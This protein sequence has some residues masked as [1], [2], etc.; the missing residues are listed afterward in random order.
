MMFSENV[1][2]D[3]APGSILALQFTQCSL[4][5]LARLH[6]ADINKGKK[7]GISNLQTTLQTVSEFSYDEFR[8]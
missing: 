2:G 1:I 4:C 7:K 3:S 6:A 8:C 5:P